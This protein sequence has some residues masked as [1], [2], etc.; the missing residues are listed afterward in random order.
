MDKHFRIN[1]S[2]KD[3]LQRISIMD[4]TAPFYTR[5]RLTILRELLIFIGICSACSFGN[6]AESYDASWRHIDSLIADGL[7]SSALD[8]TTALYSAAK[9]AQN[10]DQMVRALMYRMRLESYREEDALA[11]T[12]ER[13]VDEIQQAPFPACAILSSMLA[14]CYRHYYNANRWRFYERSQTVNFER[15]DIRTW[16]LRTITEAIA[17][18]YKA[19]LRDAARLKKI[20]LSSF[21]A[22]IISHPESE[23]R[24]TL[25]DLLCHRA[26]DYF[27][28]DDN[29]L[30][31]PSS[32]FRLEGA[33]YFAPFDK[34]MKLRITTEDTASLKYSAIT[35][36]RD[37]IAF[38]AS[39]GSPAALVD[40]DLRRIEF[41]RQ[42]TAHP[43][44]DSLCLEALRL[45]RKRFSAHES[46][47]EI[48]F[49]TAQL[50]R[51]QTN[52]F[53][54][55]T[56]KKQ[57]WMNREAIGICDSAIKEFPK[58]YGAE[59]CKALCDEIRQKELSFTIETVNVPD[60]P[61]KALVSYAN[62]TKIYWRAVA[63]SIDEWQKLQSDRNR[64]SAVAMLASV[65]PAVAWEN[66][67]PDPGD[68]L[69]HTV[70]AALPALSLGHY[71]ILC[72]SNPGFLCE[73]EIL[74]YTTV[75]ISRIGFV[76]RTKK[77]GAQELCLLDRVSGMPVAEAKVTAV[78]NV[79]D[80]SAR[81]YKRKTITSYVTDGHG[82]VTVPARKEAIYEF[83]VICTKGDDRFDSDRRFYLHRYNK[84]ERSMRPRTF[85]FTDRSIYRPGQTIYFKAVMLSTDGD[86]SAIVP[87]EKTSVT[88]CNVHGK[89]VSRLDL[90]S[91]KYGTVHGSFIAPTGTLGGA[92]TI[93]DNSGSATIYVEEYKRPGFS[94]AILPHDENRKLGD[95]VYV[96][97]KASFYTGAA[98]SGAQVRYRVVRVARFTQYWWQMRMPPFV[99][100]ETEIAG[101]K[102]LTD[103]TGGVRI[104]FVAL[105]DNTISREDKPVFT[106]N[107]SIDVT[108][109][110]GETQS[111]VGS[112]SLG[113]TAATLTLDIAQMVSGDS[114]AVAVRSANCD[115]VSTPA[116]GSFSIYRLKSPQ[117]VLRP[118]IWERPDTSVLTRKQ[119]SDMFPH[120]PFGDEDD[121]ST[122]KRGKCVFRTDFDTKRSAS[123]V[124]RDL[125]SWKQG[126]YVADGSFIDKHGDTIT[127]VRYFTLYNPGEKRPLCSRADLFIPIRDTV[128]AGDTARFLI[129][130]GYDR[131]TVLCEVEHRGE[132]V[133]K[134]W[135]TLRNEQRLIEI[136]VKKEHRGGLTLHTVFM[137]DNRVYRTSAQV[138]VPWSDKRLSLSFATFRDKL[139]PSQSEQWKITVSGA[140]GDSAA[141]EMVATLYDASLDAF[142]PNQWNF[143]IYPS[144][145]GRLG[146]H[147]DDGFDLQGSMSCSHDWNEI[148]PWPQR[149]YPELNW[150]GCEFGD[151]TP[152]YRG[153]G[154][155]YGAG[156]SDRSVMKQGA[157][158]L[159]NAEANLPQSLLSPVARGSSK[160]AKAAPPRSEHFSMNEMLKAGGSGGDARR[161]LAQ[162]PD[163]SADGF[164]QIAARS[165]LGET[166]FFFPTLTTNDKGEIIINFTAPE[167]LSRWKMLGFAHT[168]DL[169]FG[170]LTDS[171]VTRKELM[172]TSS[173]PRFLRENDTVAL[174]AMVTNLSE[175]ALKGEARLFI[176]DAATMTPLDTACGNIKA[177][178]PF[179]AGKGGGCAVSWSV[180]VPQ[181]IGA[182]TVRF[183]AMTSKFSDGEELILPVLSDRMLVTETLPLHIRKK[184]KSS[185]TM[186][187][188]VSG[189]QG[190]KTLRNHR[191]TLEFTSNPLWYAVT[192]LPGLMDYSY[193]CSEQI[194]SG[195][196]ASCIAS[197]ITA[198]FP[199]MRHVFDQWK[200]ISPGALLSNLEK[201]EHLKSIAL[202][203]TPWLLDGKDES[204]RKRRI[205]LLF[206]LNTMADKK[207]GAFARLE[208]MQ[209]SNGGWP[210]FEGLS[211]D[212]LIT[213]H[214]AT[215]LGRMT[216]LGAIDLKE[217]G[218]MAR[219]VGRAI[220]YLDER[221][222][223]D[224]REVVREGHTGEDNLG[225]LQIQYLYMKSFF[226]A[227][228][229]PGDTSVAF[230]YYLGQAKKFFLRKKRPMQAMIALALHRFDE[231]AISA[232]II[233]VLRENALHD[234]E[235][236]MYWKEMYEN[237]SW[238]WFD[239]PIESQ[240]LMA[241]AFDEAAGDRAAVDEI[242]T[243]LLK[244]RQ[245]QGW[246]TTRATVD[247]C[248]ALLG[249]GTASIAETP[250]I[251]VALG[252]TVID[253]SRHGD[254]LPEAGSGYFSASWNAEAIDTAMGNVTVT[255]AKDGVAWGAL[256]RQ[257]FEQLDK[258][259][260]HA[261]PLA[262][263][264]KLFVKRDSPAG[265]RIE[266]VLENSAL[267]TGDRIVVRIELRTDR[268][269]EYVHLKDMRAGGFEPLN[270]FSGRRYRDGLG[271]YESTTDAATNFFFDRLRKGVYVFEYPLS[272]SHT[273]NFSNGITTVQCMY[274]P[275]FA[276][277]SEGVRVR[278]EK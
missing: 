3:F 126:V 17:D 86:R 71:V 189:N 88:L 182:V 170:F 205:G 166:A 65:K 31:R 154:I 244:S 130:S 232:K 263:S 8:S 43:A 233:R 115:G 56:D 210:W 172:I 269:M 39:D 109:P 106:Y 64:D 13:L 246:K 191:L 29:E 194:F 165:K 51:R 101:G 265:P 211:D 217:D 208:K 111:D 70:E 158:A 33:E 176:F 199:L 103:D 93:S 50:Y 25:Y 62:V 68:Y 124:I 155:G 35:L 250:R 127:D 225:E 61:F 94:V 152:L 183:A 275:E 262:V 222:K 256:Y 79:Y 169:R 245:T 266:P 26:I 117:S 1:A 45:L 171:L 214:I 96:R 41:V 90:V 44:G 114:M 75:Q 258:I 15:G 167:A 63:L 121:I 6:A 60:A 99:S 80:E 37:C 247:A 149:T 253:P 239:A 66:T 105:A 271:Y 277:H 113:Y 104:G 216:L 32:E 52:G 30:I 200:N 74:L 257:Y 179:S 201:N 267:R 141:A 206:D 108:D 129:G 84:Q 178:R 116:A 274:A 218:N 55:R 273:G 148:R 174:S 240:A 40:A 57:R 243:W 143:S 14:E 58:S 219:M 254:A 276:S 73:K 227:A 190:S 107:V 9:Q 220:G 92:M 221:V 18:S 77:D 137:R 132:I 145:F 125:R 122:W 162:S 147:H 110:A 184:G 159:L 28:T 119:Y 42:H 7:T 238:G 27:S 259:T 34:F 264:K 252:D 193:E 151:V 168:K 146:W 128:E 207:A 95:S 156:F 203:E 197:H 272:A 142:S 16:D 153:R 237:A 131:A 192:A 198:S 278:I 255:G 82:I 136:P 160:L 133:R 185:F 76:S 91:N 89:E 134:E 228:N 195:L 81:D 229:L 223:E 78:A 196:Y 236:G 19:S 38:H 209:L 177:V 67:L 123:V 164:E 87:D 234:E 2:F 202:E 249:R 181:G 118:R 59:L 175:E 230:D 100:T 12:I 83:S 10:G 49:A 20:E 231:T 53:T 24:P 268:D 69:L 72:S 150:F 157:R 97:A 163:K 120:D 46:S 270:V 23:L 161:D 226:A 54:P 235:K 241:E 213:Q 138:T 212:R 251:T 102:A 36:L 187:G 85:F 248:Y 180:T 98:V 188:L 11:K 22:T 242:R 135:I 215:G 4:K 112:V 140:D 186:S 47:T 144:Y 139:L 173:V 204:E 224:Y 5:S 260:G 261:T 21:G 48:A